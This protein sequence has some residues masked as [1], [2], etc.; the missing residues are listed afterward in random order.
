M[1]LPKRADILEII[2]NNLLPEDFAHCARV[3]RVAA[4][5]GDRFSVDRDKASMAGLMHDFCR[6]MSNEEL[7]S[8]SKEFGIS[9]LDAD[10]EV[11]YL[12]HGPLG[13]KI[14][15]AAFPDT[16][17]EVLHAIEVHTYGSVQMNNLDMLIYVAD[18]IE[19]GRDIEGLENIRKVA[20]VSLEQAFKQAYAFTVSQL[21]I[22]RKK[23]HPATVDVWNKLIAI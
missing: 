19:P 6:Y 21:V 12:L 8:K 2:K 11:P 10:I 1:A 4:E 17:L 18:L 13:A 9:I 16:D 5:L 23:I 15:Q 7:L 20:K 22:K 3:E 14:I